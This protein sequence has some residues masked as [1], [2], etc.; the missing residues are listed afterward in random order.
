MSAARLRKLKSIAGPSIWNSKT[1]KTFVARVWN[2]VCIGIDIS[3]IA[4][5]WFVF[6]KIIS[7]CSL[8]IFFLHSIFIARQTLEKSIMRTR[9]EVCSLW[10]IKSICLSNCR[11]DL[12]HS[13]ILNQI[14]FITN[15]I[16]KRLVERANCPDIFLLQRCDARVIWRLFARVL[17]NDEE[18]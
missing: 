8:F 18:N 2:Y 14:F 10:N 9:A 12:S 15:F 16:R 13:V 17:P 11:F 7:A 3:I 6:K 1:Q 5:L 4:V